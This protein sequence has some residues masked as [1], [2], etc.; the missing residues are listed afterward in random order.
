M[1]HVWSTMVHTSAVVVYTHKK[2]S[3]KKTTVGKIPRSGDGK[4]KVFWIKRKRG[5]MRGGKPTKTAARLPLGLAH[6]MRRR[7]PP[8]PGRTPTRAH[9]A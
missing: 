5:G 1:S 6:A 3:K 8:P 7:L 2:Y 4:Q 9:T